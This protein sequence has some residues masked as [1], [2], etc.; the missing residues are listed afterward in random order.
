MAR[1]LDQKTVDQLTLADGQFIFDSEPSLRGF[2][3][4][5]RRDA[6]GRLAK[7]WIVQYRTPDG[8]RRRTLGNAAR[9]TAV[10]ARKKAAAWI[11]KV[12]AGD[13]PAAT[14][15][16]ERKA[17]ALKFSKAVEQYL[18]MK[19]S[20]V[21][22]SSLKIM[23]LYL[24]GRYFSSTLHSMPVAKI[25]KSH[26]SQSL[27]ALSSESGRSTARAARRH[28]A[29]FFAWCV[30]CGH[31]DI[32]PCVGAVKFNAS[33]SRDRV[34]SDDEL[35]AV[36]NAC[37][38]DHYGRIVRLLALT[39]CRREEIGG[40]RW[41][42]VDLDDATITLP[43][44]RTKNGHK[45][46]VP[47]APAAVDILSSIERIAGR[48]FVFG[49]YCQGFSGWAEKKQKLGD[50]ISEPWT[51]HDLRRSFR[52]GLGRLGVPPHIAERCV[53]HHQGGMEDVYNKYRYEGEIADA[54]MRWADHV[55]SV[56]SGTARKV[57]PIKRT[58]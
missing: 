47:L 11:A 20:E 30:T 48:E 2:A 18:S 16:D 10:V 7:T 8:Q 27:V 3:V 23:R 26:V 46:L 56:A 44:E 14:N 33:D 58:A 31:S 5:L 41:E 37:G 22:G 43:K 40:L 13:D 15:D 19:E 49:S 28:L 36:W 4:R 17:T 51:L 32:N 57:V 24:T 45:H 1:I 9:M 29:A 50:G 34:L 55:L 35:R 53:N 6:K 52:T 25:T 38:D 21:R 54:M 12:E 39:G 42:E